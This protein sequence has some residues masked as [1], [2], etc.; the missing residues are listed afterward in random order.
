MGL[1]IDTFGMRAQ[2]AVG[3]GAV[4][5]VLAVGAGA[6]H[7]WRAHGGSEARQWAA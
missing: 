4:V 7:R 2:F 6:E 1:A 3:A 5:L